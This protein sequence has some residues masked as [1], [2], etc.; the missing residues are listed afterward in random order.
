MKYKDD[1]P[2]AKERWTALWEGRVLD[3]PC[4]TVNAPNGKPYLGPKASSPEEQWLDPD[5][6]VRTMLATFDCT[7]HGGESFPSYLLMAG[8]V[9]NTY[10]AAPRFNWNTIWFEPISVDWDNPPT[11]ELD[12]DS[13]WL[14]KVS[15][16]Q[17]AA[18]AAAGYDDFLVSSGCFM[19]AGDMLAF[20]IG[21][22]EVLSCMALRP[23]WTRAAILQLTRNWIALHRH[24]R[25]V[26]APT[27][28]DWYG[29]AG[30]MP[31]WAPAPFIATQSDLSC[32]ISTAMF[33]E[34]V[35]PEL[36]LIGEAFGSVWYHLDGQ[37]AFHHLPRLLSLPYMKVI[38]F[39]PE[40]GTPPNGP[41]YIEFYRKV[42]EAG[43]IVHVQLPAEY[44]EPVLKQVDPALICLMTQC[45]SPEEAEEL[46][47]RSARWAA[48]I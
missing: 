1:W 30:W 3:R 20:V 47:T 26:A 12:W 39:V 10:G 14:G 13:P 37:S 5:V 2:K 23:E 11:F 9:A 40:A 42:Q 41:E 17:R 24:F 43:K 7:Y 44:V 28:V 35:V 29:N 19:S 18:L 32:M 22:Q 27:H 21:T 6:I 16:L 36:D 46:L 34:F 38:Q 33:E 45:N 15:A 8:W 4:I 31:Y 25:E 48:R